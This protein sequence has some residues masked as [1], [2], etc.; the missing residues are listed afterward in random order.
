MKTI[1]MLGGMSWESTVEYYR[2]LNQEMARRH[3]G[4]T[5]AAV[6]MHS[7][8]FA[9]LHS[10]LEMEEWEAIAAHL[11]WLGRGLRLAGADF[12][13]ICTNTMHRVA[14][15]VAA[16]SDLAVLHIG[17]ATADAVK[18]AGAKRVGLLGTL[19]TMEQGFLRDRLLDHELD[20]LV[21]EQADRNLVH[22]VIFEELCRGDFRAESRVEFL[23]IM[24]QLAAAGA[25]GVIL[26]C[27]EIP[28]LVRPEDTNIPLFDTTRIHALAAVE[29]ALEGEEEVL[30]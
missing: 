21:P 8:N 18:A 7:V 1:G 11:G 12:L 26:A 16:A 4:L 3:G 22:R 27:T 25:E 19:P 29:R 15:E 30:Y 24:E 23:R 17:D 13:L 6:V 5:S 10:L 28:L 14:E 2:I 20:V 9:E